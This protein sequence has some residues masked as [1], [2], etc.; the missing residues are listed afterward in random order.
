MKGCRIQ[1]CLRSTASGGIF[2]R[3]ISGGWSSGRMMATSW[4]MGARRIRPAWVWLM[5]LWIVRVGVIRGL[6][7]RA[8][9]KC[10]TTVR[11]LDALAADVRH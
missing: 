1:A 6:M 7:T 5:D 9:F 2:R 8:S 4:L 10:T 11:V 3:P